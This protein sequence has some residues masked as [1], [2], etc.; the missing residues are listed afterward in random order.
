V[1]SQNKPAGT[2]TPKGMPAQRT[3][4][5]GPGWICLILA[6]TTLV[7]YWPITHAQ[8]INYDDN[9]YV[10]ENPEVQAGL[11]WASVKWAFTTRHACNWHPLT[12]LSHILDAQ[13][14]GK[15]A[16]GAHL[17]NLV[18]HCGNAVLLFLLLCEATNRR[19]PSAVVA[20]LFALHPLHVESVAWVAERKD[21]LSTFFGFLTLWTYIK[22][23]RNEAQTA[24]P[25]KNSGHPFVWYGLSVVLFALGLM[26]KPMLVTLPFV[27]LLLDVWPLGRVTGARKESTARRFLR[28]LGEKSPFFLLSLAGCLVTT[29]AQKDAIQPL[30]HLAFPDR[31]ANAFVAYARYVYK[32][33]W[34]A[35]LALPYLHP[36]HWPPEEVWVLVLLVGVVSGFAA[37]FARK[38]PFVFT[39]W[40]WFVG[41]L[42]PVIGLIQ[43]GTQAM[44]DRYTYLPVIGLFIAVTWAAANACMRWRFPTAIP[45]CA[46]IL[47]L[48]ACG[49]ATWMQARYWH[50]SETLFRHSAAVTK[51]NFIAIE[52]VGGVLFERGR[53]DE[54]LELYR[55]AYAINPR[56]AE[57][58]NS[59]GAV[60]ATKGNDEAIE[61]FRKALELQPTHADALVN[62]GNALAK[63]GEAAESLKY[64]QASLNVKPDN[65]EARNNFGNALA[66]LGR[67]DEAIVEYQV[68]LK[69]KPDAPLIHKNLGEMFAAKRRF[70]DSINEYRQ[71]LAFTND[72]AAH[73]AIALTFAV[74]AKWDEAIQHFSE[75]LRFAPTN[76]QAEYNLG[77]ALRLQGRL[78]EAVAHLRQATHLQPQFPLAH[79]NLGCVL[80]AQG[81]REDAMLELQEALRQEPNYPE[82]TE[83]L[84]GLTEESDKKNAGTASGKLQQ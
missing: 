47:V 16:A 25:V 44:A 33:V 14:F 24:G 53:L 40:F 30:E 39:G 41:T 63:N 37:L 77:Y 1:V 15:A 32:T 56:Y 8:F 9:V 7:A 54:A 58:A 70:D 28:L 42:V 78:V 84:R 46:S 52:N 13:L 43:V 68:A 80:E 3:S 55:Q 26:S 65:Y 48:A 20:G 69:S 79:Y 27:M 74:Q 59:I 66:K 5:I 51:D 11:S 76:A 50:D 81:R 62:L 38:F 6:A 61:W 22:Y 34:P 19:W 21:V 12:W 73:Y 2:E 83:K 72:P 71:V 31:V 17:E 49:A 60:L 35:E 82:A 75:T 64:F 10:T 4:R 29:W 23:L 45:A 18:F 36:G 67:F 57:A